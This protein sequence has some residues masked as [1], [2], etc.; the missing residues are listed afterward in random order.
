MNPKTTWIILAGGLVFVGCGIEAPS[1]RYS[2]TTLAAKQVDKVRVFRGGTP[3]RP[4]QELG[5]VEVS[6]PTVFSGGPYGGGKFEGGCTYDEAVDM[7]TERAADSGADAIYALHSAAAGN[8]SVVS[9]TAVAVRFTAPATAPKAPAAPVTALSIDQRLQKL[10]ELNEQKL[11][12]DD[13][14]ARRKAEILH[15]L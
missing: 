1:V 13:E 15:D 14:Y 10:K 9:M 11:I 8:G 12:T 5:T 6:C 7:A 2:G 3:D 4:F